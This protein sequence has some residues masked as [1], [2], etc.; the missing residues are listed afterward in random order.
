[1]HIQSRDVA[2]WQQAEDAEH[3]QGLF[4]RPAFID[5]QWMGYLRTQRPGLIQQY[6]NLWQSEGSYMSPLAKKLID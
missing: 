5:P 1:M 2:Y 6:L 4:Q 3:I